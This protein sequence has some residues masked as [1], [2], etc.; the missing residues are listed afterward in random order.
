MISKQLGLI[1]SLGASVPGR[2]EAVSALEGHWV[3]A[4]FREVQLSLPANVSPMKVWH[5]G[6]LRF[7]SGANS[8]LSLQN[9]L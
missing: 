2:V 6:R 4:C 3:D 1:S 7:T 8:S 5:A 9:V